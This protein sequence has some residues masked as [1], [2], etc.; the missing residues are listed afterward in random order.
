MYAHIIKQSAHNNSVRYILFLSPFYWC[1]SRGTERLKYL[2]QG[3]KLETGGARIKGAPGSRAQSFA[4]LCSKDK[5]GEKRSTVVR[6]LLTSF[7][8]SFPPCFLNLWKIKHLSGSDWNSHSSVS[9]F[10]LSWQRM[11]VHSRS[12]ACKS[13]LGTPG[14][15]VEQVAFRGKMRKSNFK[16]SSSALRKLFLKEKHLYSKRIQTCRKSD[17]WEKDVLCVYL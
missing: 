6:S 1:R 8:C 7:M 14:E 4:M 9:L 5:R 16:G 10:L 13:R 2:T 3:R 15:S 11:L 12:N 17:I